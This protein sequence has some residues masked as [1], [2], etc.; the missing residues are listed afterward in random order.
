MFKREL[1]ET[2]QEYLG[3]STEKITVR[4]LL[5]M[6]SGLGDCDFVPNG[7]TKFEWQITVAQK[8]DPITCLKN[9]K[10]WY[11]LHHHKRKNVTEAGDPFYS[12]LG[13]N[14]LGLVLASVSGAQRWSDFDQGLF[15]AELS[16]GIKF[17]D[18]TTAEYKSYTKFDLPLGYDG[19]KLIRRL[20][21][22]QGW[23]AGDSFATA[24]QAATLLWQALSPQGKLFKKQSTRKQV[25]AG[26]LGLLDKFGCYG[27]GSVHNLGAAHHG[28]GHMG[29]AAGFVS[30]GYYSPE[31]DTSFFLAVSDNGIDHHWLLD[32][33]RRSIDAM[34]FDDRLT[35]ELA[36]AVKTMQGP[37]S[38]AQMLKREFLWALS[39]VTG[40]LTHPA[41]HVPKIVRLVQND[42]KKLRMAQEHALKPL[43]G[44]LTGLTDPAHFERQTVCESSRRKNH[45]EMSKK[46]AVAAKQT[47]QKKL[48]AI[49]GQVLKMKGV[50]AKRARSA[51][52]AK[53]RLQK[54][55]V[56]GHMVQGE[57][58]SELNG[59]DPQ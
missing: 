31:M 8:M 22:I 54:K 36:A 40:M 47:S 15:L 23:S 41:E 53:E 39:Y 12:S 5:E 14:I 44:A 43:L 24:E 9:Y 52:L 2:M 46:K 1:G 49:K 35:A 50:L 42:L 18:K 45:M 59:L 30:V 10:K 27:M 6:R 34:L 57:L 33:N 20:P 25:M 3:P 19:Y 7:R 51:E 26:P 37:M 58:S 11:F 13:F 56:A 4:D 55:S 21:C 32:A 38:S 48:D 17:C 16:S 28:I 29:L